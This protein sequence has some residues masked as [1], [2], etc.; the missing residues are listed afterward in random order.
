[1]YNDVSVKYTYTQKGVNDVHKLV[2]AVCLLR[3]TQAASAVCDMAK[4]KRQIK[5]TQKMGKTLVR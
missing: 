3:P 1:M 5:Q 2:T 4:Y